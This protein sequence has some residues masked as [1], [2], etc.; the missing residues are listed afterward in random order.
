[1]LITLLSLL[2]KILLVYSL[3]IYTKNISLLV[4]LGDLSNLAISSNLDLSNF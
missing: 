4:D 3:G 1:M 2:W